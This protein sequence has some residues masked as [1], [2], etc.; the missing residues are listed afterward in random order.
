MMFIYQE[1]MSKPQQKLTQ[2]MAGLN[3]EHDI[4]EQRG[5]RE[6][7]SCIYEGVQAPSMLKTYLRKTAR[8]EKCCVSKKVAWIQFLY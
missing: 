5:A 4:Q 2:D 6:L 7:R 1:W 8:S 3:Q